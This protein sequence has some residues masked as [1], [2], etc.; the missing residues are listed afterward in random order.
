MRDI[1]GTFER[2]C[3]MKKWEYRKAH[4]LYEMT[5]NAF[6]KN[7][8]ELCNVED[9]S[10]I[11]KRELVEEKENTKICK[12]QFKEDFYDAECGARTLMNLGTVE[13]NN[14]IYCTNCGGKIVLDVIEQ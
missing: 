14:M 12:W 1:E 13:K 2:G 6:G 3:K 9:D 8:W 5:L 4:C 10:Y 7:G 11:F